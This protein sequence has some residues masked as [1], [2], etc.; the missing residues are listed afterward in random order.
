MSKKFSIFVVWLFLYVGLF[1]QTPTLQDVTKLYVATFNR[2]PDSDGLNYWLYD[3]GLDLEGIARSFFDQP[4]TKEKYPSNTSIDE[5]ITE[6]YHN[7]FNRDPKQNGLDYWQEQLSSGNIRRSEFILAVMNGAM[8]N[9]AVI[10]SNK[11]QAGEYFA[12]QGLDD[13]KEAKKVIE[14]IDSSPD[15]LKKAKELVDNIANGMDDNID[16][17]NDSSDNQTSNNENNSNV[18]VPN[19]WSSDEAT[20]LDYLNKVRKSLGLKA[21]NANDNLHTSALN[22]SKYQVF[23]DEMG[24]LETEGK[25]YFSGKSI[26]DRI[27]NAGYTN[28]YTIGENV[29]FD[30]EPKNNVD[31]LL[32]AIYHRKGFLSFDFTDIGVGK[33]TDNE[34]SVRVAYTYDMGSKNFSGSSEDKDY[35]VYPI[36]KLNVSIFSGEEPN[37]IAGHKFSGNPA[38]IFFNNNKV[39]CS[40]ISMDSFTLTDLTDNI[41]TENLKILTRDND[42]NGIFGSCDFALFPK[43]REKFGHKYQATFKYEDNSGSHTVN[44]NFYIPLP[45]NATLDNILNIKDSESS[46]TINK[47]ENYYI[48]VEPTEDNPYIN[49][50]SYSTVGDISLD[51]LSYYD[52]NTLKINVSPNSSSEGQIKFDLNNGDKIV[53]ITVQ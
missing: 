18:A 11:E 5:F 1:A 52:N 34:G 9:D 16:N 48:F 21:F 26:Q 53:Y 24:H 41:E 45:P 42:S 14:L 37:P 2:A 44:W 4:E 50:I 12:E 28:Y 38:S 47:G 20:A 19:G 32:S 46:F 13:V 30:T 36:D 51:D 6:V 22:H 35:V 10:L 31:D 39:D 23:N 29:A 49:N 40:S 8:N 3:S 7:L 17:T 43:E 15:S 25:E 27:E 33:A